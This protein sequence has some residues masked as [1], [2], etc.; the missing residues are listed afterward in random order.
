[1]VSAACTAQCCSTGHALAGI[2]IATMTSL[3]RWPMT[4]SETDIATLVRCALVEVCTVPVLLVLCFVVCM[5]SIYYFNNDNNPL[6]TLHIAAVNTINPMS[7][8]VIFGVLSYTFL[9]FFWAKTLL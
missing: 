9:V 8:L 7:C 3:C 6:K 5:S 2:A 4:D 1:V